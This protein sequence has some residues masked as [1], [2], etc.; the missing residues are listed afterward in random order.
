LEDANASG[1]RR[2]SAA[3]VLERFTW[4]RSA[5]ALQSALLAVDATLRLKRRS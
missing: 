2:R 1:A 4:E 5:D 3:A